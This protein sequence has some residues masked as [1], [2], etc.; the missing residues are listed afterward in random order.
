MNG[1]RN[2]PEESEPRWYPDR[3]PGERDDRYDGFNA[4]EPQYEEARNWGGDH[5]P[6]L[7]EDPGTYR[8]QPIERGPRYRQPGPPV[9]APMVP[10]SVAAPPPSP[11]PPVSPGLDAA[12]AM[13]GYVAPPNVPPVAEQTGG[14]VYRTRRAG[15]AALIGVAAAVSELLILVQVLAAAFGSKGTPGTTLAA[16][17]GVPLAAIGLYALATGAASAAPTSGRAWSRVPLAYLPVGLVL[18]V[19]AGLAVR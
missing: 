3:Y 17:C 6:P 9:A 4:P 10:P 14:A 2:Y 18:L 12:G 1:M 15:V 5:A 16:L 13:P 8:T 7:A 19:A 11:A